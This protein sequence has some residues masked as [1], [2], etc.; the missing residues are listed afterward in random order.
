MNEF[1]HVLPKGENSWKTIAC[2][3]VKQP[4]FESSHSQLVPLNLLTVTGMLARWRG[5]YWWLT[6]VKAIICPRGIRKKKRE[7]HGKRKNGRKPR[8]RMGSRR[9]E[10]RYLTL[11]IQLH[12]RKRWAQW[13]EC[14]WGQKSFGWEVQ[15]AA[16]SSQNLGLN[17]WI[18]LGY[19]DISC[20]L[21]RKRKKKIPVWQSPSGKRGFI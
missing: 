5:F 3:I 15:N 4:S 19:S 6:W 21:Q 7:K 13:A 18:C 16:G 9:S 14:T 1:K 11:Q 12:G 10:S 8:R 20:C 17:E 2:L